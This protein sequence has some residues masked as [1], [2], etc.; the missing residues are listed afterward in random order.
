V[1]KSH[2]IGFHRLP[3]LYTQTLLYSWWVGVRY[4]NYDIVKNVHGHFLLMSHN[5]KSCKSSHIPH[6]NGTSST[7]EIKYLSWGTRQG[8]ETVEPCG[9]NAPRKHLRTSNLHRPCKVVIAS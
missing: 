6:T 7:A 4:Y 5:V 3:V 9:A 1:E 8:I 2:S